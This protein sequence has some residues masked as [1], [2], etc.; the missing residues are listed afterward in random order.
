MYMLERIERIA[1]ERIFYLIYRGGE[2]RK[3]ED[4]EKAPGFLTVTET[5][6]SR[7]VFD[8]RDDDD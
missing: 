5:R 8:G 2:R 7:S 3:E 4:S 6:K 1:M